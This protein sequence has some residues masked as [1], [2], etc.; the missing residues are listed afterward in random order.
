M[1]GPRETIPG[2]PN[3]PEASVEVFVQQ[4]KAG[5]PK[6]GIQLNVWSKSL[7]WRPQKTLLLDPTQIPDLRRQLAAAEIHLRQTDVIPGDTDEMGK[8]LLFPTAP[9]TEPVKK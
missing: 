2:A 7:G 8:L 4:T 6:V 9:R 5:V 1:A 3:E